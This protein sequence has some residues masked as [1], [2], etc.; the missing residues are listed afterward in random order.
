MSS[1]EVDGVITPLDYVNEELNQHDHDLLEACSLRY[2][3]LYRYYMKKYKKI[4]RKKILLDMII[5]PF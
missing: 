2:N 4:R 3:S 5:W 1:D